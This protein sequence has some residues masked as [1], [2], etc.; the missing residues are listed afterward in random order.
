MD[1]VAV[2]FSAAEKAIGQA[3]TSFADGWLDLTRQELVAAR[4]QINRA[5]VTLK[6]R[7]IQ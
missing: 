6:T 4:D 2:R 7:G 3:R 5:L 1:G